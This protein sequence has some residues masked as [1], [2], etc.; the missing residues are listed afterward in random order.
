MPAAG[1]FGRDSTLSQHEAVD[2][3]A[4]LETFR[5]PLRATKKRLSTPVVRVLVV[6]H[7]QPQFQHPDAHVRFAAR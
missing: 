7:T 4:M 1:A 5:E 2:K 6:Q 3:T